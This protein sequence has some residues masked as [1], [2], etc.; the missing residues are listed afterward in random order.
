VPARPPGKGKLKREM[1]SGARKEVERG[2]TAFGR[3]F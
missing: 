1:K 2:L 3:N